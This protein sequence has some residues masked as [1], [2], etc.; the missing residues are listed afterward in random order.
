MTKFFAKFQF[1]PAAIALIGMNLIPLIG[2]FWFGWDAG[3]IVFL[4]WLENVVIGI[5]NIPK[6]L[7]SRA[8]PAGRPN[9]RESLG[10]LMFLAGFFSI[11]YGLFCFGHYMFLSATY[12]SLPEWGE[13]I[14][15]L[16]G[17]ILIWS[18]L[19]LT[20]SHGVSMFVNFYGK[21]EYKTRTPNKQMFMPYTRILILHVVIVFSS[22]LAVAMGEGLATLVMLIG[23]K[24]GFDLA[25]HLVEHSEKE[26]LIAPSVS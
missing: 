1:T 23:V 4:Y 6:I 22:L 15:A 17:S 21:G 2:V 14:P 13:I 24:I 16:S 3:T 20:F 18:L 26:S 10:G 12:E 7:S 19:G 25:A 9:R 5:L 8:G 11:H